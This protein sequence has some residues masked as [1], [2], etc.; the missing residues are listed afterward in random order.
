MTMQITAF[1]G[2]QKAPFQRAIIQ[3]TALEAGMTSNLTLDTFNQV[4]EL[5]GCSSGDPQSEETLQC[6]RNLPFET[7][8][9]ITVTQQD[10]TSAT[11]DGDT[12]LPVVD[13][14][15][16]PIPASQLIRDGKFS[17][18]A[19]IIGWEQDDGSLFASVTIKTENDTL[20]YLKIFFPDLKDSTLSKLLS[21]YPTSAFKANDAANLSAE[22]FRSTQTFRDA[23]IHARAF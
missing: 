16:L 13:G 12:Y 4:A 23:L 21:V 5:S 11:N 2:S 6:L 22:F 8:L 20:N 7:L 18:V 14:D 3:S 9:N 1:G 17:K 19:A 15:F 10:S